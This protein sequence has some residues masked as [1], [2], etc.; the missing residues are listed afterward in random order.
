LAAVHVTS[1]EVGFVVIRTRPASSTA[2]HSDV[3]GHV[4]DCRLFAPSISDVVQEGDAAVG[5]VEINARPEPSIATHNESETQEI[6]VGIFPLL[7]MF[8]A[9]QAG[10][11]SVGSVETNA[12][13]SASTVAHSEVDGH[14]IPCSPGGWR[15]SIGDGFGSISSVVQA[16]VAAVGSVEVTEFPEL[17]TATHSEVEG[18]EMPENPFAWVNGSWLTSVGAAHE[19]PAAS[20]APGA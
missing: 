20:A 17:S 8:V 16:G 9:A 2:T 11:A 18:H 3:E 7:S 12:T 1:T 15:S 19:N 5:S 14:E 13:P 6:P 10:L 4:T